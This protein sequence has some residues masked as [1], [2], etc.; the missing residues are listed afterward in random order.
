MYHDKKLTKFV[1]VS[2][3]VQV[4]GRNVRWTTEQVLNVADADGFSAEKLSRCPVKRFL[5][6]KC[7]K[8]FYPLD[9]LQMI[10]TKKCRKYFVYH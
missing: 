5:V 9:T 7:E 2:S 10:L 3:E 8:T 1:R 4:P 6:W